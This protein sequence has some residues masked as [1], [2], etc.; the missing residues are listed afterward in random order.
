MFAIRIEP[1]F[2]GPSLPE[3]LPLLADTDQPV[4]VA[5]ENS[6]AEI[7]LLDQVRDKAVTLIVNDLAAMERTAISVG[8]GFKFDRA[9]KSTAFKALNNKDGE[10]NWR[11]LVTQMGTGVSRSLLIRIT[12]DNVRKGNS[13]TPLRT[14]ANGCLFDNVSAFDADVLL[15]LA[16]RM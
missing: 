1:N 11:G 8:V 13:V 9:L 5:W 2:N 15:G 6:R 4:E 12:S 16:S 7:A 14:I 3:M 10:L